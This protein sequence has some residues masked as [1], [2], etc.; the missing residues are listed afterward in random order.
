MCYHTQIMIWGQKVDF[1][2]SATN[3]LEVGIWVG[4]LVGWLVGLSVSTQISKQA[5]T[6]PNHIPAC[7]SEFLLHA[8]LT[9]ICFNARKCQQESHYLNS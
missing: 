5:I 8:N 7:R 1:Y 4:W 2:G 9:R 6:L 3:H